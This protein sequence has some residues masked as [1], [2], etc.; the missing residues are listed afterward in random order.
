[1]KFE[2]FLKN[3]GARGS[4]VNTE[5]NGQFL[6]LG[7]VLL[8][9]PEG[10]NVLS[11]NEM[12]APEYIENIFRDFEDGYLYKAELHDAQLPAPDASPSKIER[13]FANEDFGTIAIDNKTFG[14][15]ERSDRLY[16]YAEAE[17]G[18]PEKGDQ[19]ALVVTNGF[20]DEERVVAIILDVQYYY[21]K[22]TKKGAVEND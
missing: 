16:T 5:R 7:G 8:A 2:K 15:I 21:D 13:V 19:D 18:E 20:G 1:M 10:V 14:I 9:I 12:N 3:C 11:I 22:I 17:D 4:I 6:K